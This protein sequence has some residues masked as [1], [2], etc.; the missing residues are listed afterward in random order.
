MD[1]EYYPI[2]LNLKSIMKGKRLDDEID[3]RK[4][5]HQNIR[6][7]LKTFTLSYGFDPSF[8]C[9]MNKFHARTPPQEVSSRVWHDRMR[10]DIQKNLKDMLQRYE[11]RIK[12]NDVFIEIRPAKRRMDRSLAYVNV[13]I[14]GRLSIGRKE[15]FNY[16]DSQIAEEAK[17]V[18]PLMIPLGRFKGT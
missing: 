17:E 10:S 11:T 13:E 16:P 9:L 14:S 18:F 8:G 15:K 2:P 5:I 3:L 4:S 6:L 1:V 12:V 7:I